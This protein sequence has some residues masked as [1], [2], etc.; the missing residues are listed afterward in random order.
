MSGPKGAKRSRRE[1]AGIREPEGT[2]LEAQSK[3]N[4]PVSEYS[5]ERHAQNKKA[6]SNF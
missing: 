1:R 5:G 3:K 2:R 4:I 6:I